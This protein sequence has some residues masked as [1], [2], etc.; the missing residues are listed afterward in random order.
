[1]RATFA[2]EEYRENADFYRALREFL[3][4]ADDRARGR[5]LTRQQFLLLLAVR[6]HRNYPS[7]SVGEVSDALKLQ[8]SSTSLLIDRCVKRGHILRTEDPADRRRALVRLSEGGQALLDDIMDANRRDLG[9][10]ESALFG[11]SLQD[12]I[13]SGDGKGIA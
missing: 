4:R 6:G 7:V 5:G 10:L 2:D 1:M 3:Q 9:R 13:R 11:G 12:A 8:Q